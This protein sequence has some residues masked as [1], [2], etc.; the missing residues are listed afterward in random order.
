[1]E[2]YLSGDIASSVLVA[3]IFKYFGA[4]NGAKFFGW[5]VMLGAARRKGETRVQAVE[6][7]QGMGLSRAS[8]Y[9]VLEDIDQFIQHLEAEVMPGQKKTVDDFFEELFRGGLSQA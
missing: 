9:R 4:A 1:M 5:C 3:E 7:L 8:G 2:R 6:R